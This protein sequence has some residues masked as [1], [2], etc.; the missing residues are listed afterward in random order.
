MVNTQINMEMN[1]LHQYLALV[2]IL[3]IILITHFVL[4]NEPWSD[5]D[6]AAY[7][8]RGDVAFKGFVKFFK[9]LSDEEN[10]QIQKW[11]NYLNERKGNAVFCNVSR[12]D[13]KKMVSFSGYKSF[14]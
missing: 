8:D 12:P 11:I 4:F 3:I 13:Q 9:E 1:A 2:S 14:S 7:F 6:Q 10:E 5:I